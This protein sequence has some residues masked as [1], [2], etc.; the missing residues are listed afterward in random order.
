MRSGPPG[1]GCS[2]CANWRCPSSRRPG[3]KSLSARRS[4]PEL[5]MAKAHA[6]SLR[7]LLNVSQLEFQITTESP[8]G[9]SVARAAGQKCERCWHWEPEVG[10]NTAHP[11]LC[12]R[13][14]KVVEELA[15]K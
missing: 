6:P 10:S 8:L 11:T 4:S 1:N 15:A 9:V 13:C 7:E 5:A 14:V 2:N 3:K 12:A